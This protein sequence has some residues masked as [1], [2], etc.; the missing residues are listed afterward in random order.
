MRLFEI[1][2]GASSCYELAMRLACAVDASDVNAIVKGVTV[3]DR[4]IVPAEVVR[5]L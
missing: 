3:S 2:E 1:G 4:W 5:A